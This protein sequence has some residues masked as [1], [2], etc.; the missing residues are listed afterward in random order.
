MVWASLSSCPEASLV[1]SPNVSRPSSTAVGSGMA[2][3]LSIRVHVSRARSVNHGQR[4]RI[5]A[6]SRVRQAY[7]DDMAIFA[8]R[9]AAG[10]E[11]ARSLAGWRHADALVAGIPRGGVVVAAEVARALDLALVAVVVR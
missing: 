9:I 5:P 4:C 11:L 6:D 8:D 10:R 1:T 3:I 2:S 7:R